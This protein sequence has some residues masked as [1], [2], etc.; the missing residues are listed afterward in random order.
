MNESSSNR[1]TPGTPPPA[2]LEPAFRELCDVVARLRAPDGCPW[3]RQQTLETIKPHTLEETYELLEAIDSGDDDAISEELGD[4]L[5]QVVLDAQIA[6]DEG[7]FDLVRVIRRISHKLVARHPHVFAE[8]HAE[9]AA[10]V[11][12]HWDRIKQQEK[13]RESILDGVPAELPQLAR[14]ARITEKAARVGFDFPNRVMLFDK[15]REE[16][17]ELAAELFPGGRIPDVPADVDAQVVPDAPIE[18]KAMKDRIESEI[19]DL[20]FVVAN[21]ARRWHINPEEALR[22]S[23]RKFANRFRYI[24]AQLKAQGRAIRD[25]TLREME[26]LYQEGKRG[27]Q[28][29]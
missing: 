8:E 13:P 11:K 22:R 7:R 4:V 3:D 2:E 6:A 29:A 18:D 12:S 28:S 24:E 14:A 19:G 16:V 20:L 1:P 26:D 5:L 23:N 15:L 27:E 10:D 25:A 21:I 17:S 9:T